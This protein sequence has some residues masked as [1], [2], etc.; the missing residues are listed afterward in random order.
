MKPSLFYIWVLKDIVSCFQNSFEFSFLHKLGIMGNPVNVTLSEFGV[1]NLL[2]G[3]VLLKISFGT[4]DA[5][6]V[7]PS[8]ESILQM[9]RDTSINEKTPIV[10]IGVEDIIV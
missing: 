9:L 2:R 7:I 4:H 8:C 1:S 6:L 10:I 5:I 3:L